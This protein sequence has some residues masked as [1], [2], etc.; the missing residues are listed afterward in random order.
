MKHP[1]LKPF[2]LKAED[3]EMTGLWD[4]GCLRKARKSELTNEERKHIF[5]S[6]FHYKIKLSGCTGRVTKCKARVVVLGNHMKQGEDYLAPSLPCRE[7]RL[8]ASSWRWRQ[9]VAALSI[10]WISLKPS[11]RVSG[12]TF[13]KETPPASSS[14]LLTVS[15]RRRQGFVAAGFEDSVWVCE[16]NDTYFEQLIVSEHIDD[17]LVSCTDMA[18]LNSFKAAFLAWFDGTDYGLLTEYLGCEVVI[19]AAGNLT[20]RQSAYAERI[21]CTYEA[22]DF[23][24]VKTPLEPGKRLTK[25]DSPEFV[26]PTLHRRY[27]GV[28]L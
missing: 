6:K 26:D 12:S 4:S 20:L 25:K 1:S 19:D 11:F 24:S 17:L 14:T 8:V 15:T 5:H 7:Q 2:W 10:P 16:P 13:R 28:S 18:T 9:V 21:L 23:H 22:W 3:G 27:C